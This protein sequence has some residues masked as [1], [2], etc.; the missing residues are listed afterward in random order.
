MERHSSLLMETR[1]AIAQVLI[2]DDSPFNRL[3]MRKILET[4]GFTYAEASTGLEALNMVRSAYEREAPFSVVLMDIEMPEMDGITATRELLQ[5]AANGEV[6]L[7]VIIGCSAF[8]TEEDKAA[9]LASG[10][11]HYLEKP[12]ARVRLL[13]LVAAYCRS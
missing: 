11:A 3:V 7:P 1:C 13:E 2:V 10:M 12:V 4:V 9:A 6:T 5:L 8:S